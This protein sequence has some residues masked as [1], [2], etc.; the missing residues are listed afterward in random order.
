[1]AGNLVTIRMDVEDAR[2]LRA[3]LTRV[4]RKVRDTGG[5]YR[6]WRKDRN[7]DGVVFEITPAGQPEDNR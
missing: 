6:V 1:M 5:L 7:G 2:D 4:S 3:E